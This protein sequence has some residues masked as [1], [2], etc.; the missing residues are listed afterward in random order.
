M[1]QWRARFVSPDDAGSD[2]CLLRGEVRLATGHG[3]V[4]SAGL[5]YT[6][7]GVVEARI[8]GEPV[9][10][11]LLTPG[12][13]SYEW[14]RRYAETDVTALL[15]PTTVIGLALGNG[16]YRGRLGWTGAQAIYGDRIAGLAELRIR[17]AD[18]H[19]Q[20]VGT[21]A[22]WM[23]GPSPVLA[24]DLYDGET[25]DAARIDDAWER[26]G[27]HSP[28]WS[29][30]QV[31]DQDPGDLEPY[32]GPP[33]RR[34]DEVPPAHVWR[35]PSDRT[36][37]D[38]G[39]NV[40]GWARVRASGRRGATITVRY[41]EALENGELAVGPLRSA[42][43]TDRFILS[44]GA[45]VFEPTLTFH[46]FRYA[47]IEGWPEEGGAVEQGV[48]AVVIGS[49]LRRIGR[50]ECSHPL[51][52]RLHENAVWSMRGNFVDV[53][54]DCPQRDERLG[55]TGDI[56]AFAPSAAYLFDVE[57]FLRD[58]L[59]DVDLEQ[60]HHDGV[61]PFVVP[62]VIKHLHTDLPE[63]D[64]TAVWGDA[65]VWVPWALYQAYG[66][67]RVLEDQLASM[68]AHGRRTRAALSPAGLWQGGFQFGDWLD[69]DAPPEDPFRAKADPDVLST[70]CAYRTATLI[71]AAAA[72][73]GRPELTEEFE[74]MAR[75]VRAGFT[76]NYLRDGTIVSDCTTVYALAI[77]FDILDAADRMHAGKR[78][79]DL[80]AASGH[81]I[82]TGF[83]GTP[84]VTDALTATGH[85]DAAYRLLLQ[86]ECPSWLYPVTMGATTIWERWDS[87]LPDGTINTDGMTSFNHYALGAV[88]DWMHRTVA[89]LAPL[90]PG[91]R[92]ILVAPRPGAGVDWASAS[93]D[94]PHGTA[95]VRWERE[96]ESVRVV[97]QVPD[98]STALLRLEGADDEEVGPGTHE[99]LIG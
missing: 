77:V 94:T 1:N 28:E 17:F 37:V 36:L 61:V 97:A 25:I 80:V 74:E 30:V 56:A 32:L 70:L 90:E 29:A 54:T 72:V 18:G 33:V 47:E 4:V 45:D 59:R 22:S 76:A 6:A 55:W 83:A 34:I 13:T 60:R 84:F 8:N 95:T 68:V 67:P 65:A 27:F 64:A 5:R 71:A 88:V 78:L 3:A 12:W 19:E 85:V 21:D 53:P 57:D 93:L 15:S 91:Y 86:T 42:Q 79:R 62:D 24:N 92:R 10:G 50:F 81:R 82:S 49:D 43:A 99:R 87:M 20:V 35:S 63:P 16:W 66:H 9:S 98:G 41:A 40:V 39:Q 48:T 38:F 69:P 44:G 31:L 46:G 96:G 14:R 7:L 73:V 58:W 23:A 11:D 2:A 51:L 26:P 75:T 52:N 89:G